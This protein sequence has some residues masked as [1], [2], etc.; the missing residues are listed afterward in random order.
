MRYKK[1]YITGYRG[2]A[3]N[4]E[5]N[6]SKTSIYPIIGKNESGK[7]TSLEAIYSFDFSNDDENRG[8][9]LTN[10]ENLYSTIERPITI[11]AEIEI[12]YDFQYAEEFEEQISIFK[13][14]FII[15]NPNIEFEV[16]EIDTEQYKYSNWNFI[17]A[18]QT[19]D[20]LIL[21]K[22]G[23]RISRDLKSKTYD[24]D[25]LTDLVGAEF[26]NSFGKYLVQNLPYTLYFDDFR[27]RIPEKLYIIEDKE[28]A[29]YSKWIEY[30][31]ELFQ[32]TKTEYSVFA[33]VERSDSI[34]RSIIKEVQ[35]HLNKKLIAEWSKY[36]FE[37]SN[38][39]KIHI[40]YLDSTEGPYLQFKIIELVQI[41]GVEEE[42]FFDISDRSKGF[43]WYFNFMIKLNFNPSKRERDDKDTIYLLDE[44]GSYLHTYAL[45]K[46]AEQ[47]KNLSINNTVI[48]CTHSH[49]LLNPNFIP[50]N[51]IRLAEKT[52]KGII[53]LKQLDHKGIIR[54]NK[55]SAYQSI[56]DALEVRPP[57]VEYDFDNVILLE[58]I[59]DY[60]SFKMFTKENLSYFPC[61]SASSVVNQIPY[62]IFL[63]KKY[64]A[65]WDNDVEGRER[66][67]KAT[68]TFGEVEATKFITLDN[69]NDNKNTR[70]E[71]Y[72]NNVEIEKFNLEVNKKLQS[73]E[74]TVLGIFYAPNRLE[75]IEKYFPLT[76]SNFLKMEQ[77]LIYKL[78][79]Q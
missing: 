42:R 64:I 43:Y 22:E 31:N 21:K 56:Y 51:S 28:N 6:I 18:I 78:K 13:S 49:N 11:T 46:L 74:K 14:E 32:D 10:I 44:P 40:E 5:I 65:V 38:N 57:L 79:E 29:L 37:S 17:K 50:I 15:T 27:D 16:G 20:T 4:T 72:Y 33:I 9:H 60:Y 63:G 35:K 39:I 25:F 41:D 62:M 53:I 75:L 58:G 67:K 19:L 54:P 7:T 77:K 59:F 2:L 71:E 70:L 68:E 24:I 34:R 61:T 48:Y 12:D 69:L 52:D 73:F 55:N 1:F 26:S 45:N 30:I 8:K 47:I 3:D 76:A 36:Q 23:I 66:V